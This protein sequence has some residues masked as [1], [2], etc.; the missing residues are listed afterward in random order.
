MPSR[1]ETWKNALVESLSTGLP[2]MPDSRSSCELVSSSQWNPHCP[3]CK[4]IRT[5]FLMKNIDR[6]KIAEGDF[7]LFRCQQ[8]CVAFIYPIP[9]PAEISGFYPNDYYA[10]IEQP[11]TH[12]MLSQWTHRI[13]ELTKNEIYYRKFG[14]P[15]RFPFSVIAYLLSYAKAQFEDVPRFVPNGKLLDIGCG[16]GDY[17]VEMK[18]IGWNIFGVET[19]YAGVLTAQKKGVDVFHGSIVD[20]PFSGKMFDFIRMEDVLEHLPNPLETMIIL[21]NLL[22]DNGKVRIT[23][24]N[25]DSFTFKLFGTYWFPLETPRHL[26][27]YSPRAIRNLME[28]T[29]FHIHDMKIRSHK[30]VDVIPSLLYWLEDKHKWVYDLVARRTGILKIVRKLSFPVKWIATTLGYGSMMTIILQKKVFHD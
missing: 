29:G 7:S 23:V 21:H 3:L 9:S 22:K 24:P 30:E 26:Y 8:C 17:L 18:K 6:Q 1:I 11:Q 25:L 13:R 15:R 14:Y 5:V 12:R 28:F 4:N 2:V 19:G 20:A 16:R 10:Y 27:M